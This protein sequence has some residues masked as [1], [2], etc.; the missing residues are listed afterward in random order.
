MEKILFLSNCI[1]ARSEN[2]FLMNYLIEKLFERRRALTSMLV[3]K[4]W[5]KFNLTIY[6]SY[7]FTFFVC[8]NKT[9]ENNTSQYF[10]Q[11]FY[12]PLEFFCGRHSSISPN[13]STAICY[14]NQNPFSNIFAG[15]F[16]CSTSINFHFF[17]IKMLAIFSK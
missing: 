4:R 15:L 13:I 10:E 5:T 17:Y 12:F 9:S 7:H 1:V 6:G 14:W 11:A 16:Y 8:F 3:D 2:H